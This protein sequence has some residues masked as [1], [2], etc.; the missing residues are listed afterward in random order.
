MRLLCAAV[1]SANMADGLYQLSPGLF[2]NSVDHLL[3]GGFVGRIEAH[4]DQLV[5]LQ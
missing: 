1:N 3:T 2:E 5:M 4:L